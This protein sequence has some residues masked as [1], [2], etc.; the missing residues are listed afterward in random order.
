MKNAFD[1]GVTVDVTKEKNP[2]QRPWQ[3]DP[4]FPRGQDQNRRNE[5]RF[6][7]AG[8]MPSSYVNTEGIEFYEHAVHTP[9]TQILAPPVC[10]NHFLVMFASVSGKTFIVQQPQ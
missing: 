9:K 5:S 8:S 10:L 3:H 2:G 4:N 7:A 6:D 1:E